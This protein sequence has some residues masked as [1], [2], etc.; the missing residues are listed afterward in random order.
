MCGEITEGNALGSTEIAFKK[1]FYI[2]KV[3]VL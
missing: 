1:L 3:F 2:D